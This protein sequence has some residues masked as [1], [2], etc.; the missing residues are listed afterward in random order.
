MSSSYLPGVNAYECDTG[1]TTN[2]FASQFS[3][4]E[5]EFNEIRFS[6]PH[7]KS[8]ADPLSYIY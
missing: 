6:N 8:N 3:L 2:S 5:N 4:R 1:D 7:A